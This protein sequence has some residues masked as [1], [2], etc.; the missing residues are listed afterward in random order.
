M[1]QGHST[2]HVVGIVDATSIMRFGGACGKYRQHSR[3]LQPSVHSSMAGI[4][5]AL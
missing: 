3:W 4:L 5:L 1:E 2:Q